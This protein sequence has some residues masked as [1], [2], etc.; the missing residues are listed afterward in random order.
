MNQSDIQ[1]KIWNIADLLRGDFKRSNY[2]RIILPFTVLRRLECV[3]EPIREK[4]IQ[5]HDKIKNTEVNID[6]ILKSTL[7]SPFYNLSE[8]TLASLGETNTRQNISDYINKF[9]SP[10]DKIFENFDFDKWLNDLADAD[11]LFQITQKF[12]L[13]DLHPSR[14]SNHDMGLIFEHLIYKFAESANDT[15]GEFYTPRDVVDLATTLIFDRD[16]DIFSKKRT[17]KTI[18]DPACGTG[19]FLASGIER[20]QQWTQEEPLKP[21]GQELNRESYAIAI[22]DMTIKGFEAKNIHLGNTL[23]DDKL[24]NERFDYCLANPPFGVDW[25]KKETAVRQEHD[26]RGFDGRFGAGL[27]RVSD[28]ALLFLQHLIAKMTPNRTSN[29]PSRASNNG[30]RI[31]IILNGSPLFTGQ[32]GGG[33]SEIRRWILEED[34]LETIIAL[35]TDMFYN[36]GIATYIWLLSNNKPS[37][38]AGKVQLVDATAAWVS[39]RKSIGSKRRE[40]SDQQIKDVARLVQDYKNKKQIYKG[41]A[42]QA[43]V[44][45]STAFGYRRITIERPLQLTFAAQDGARRAALENDKGWKKLAAERQKKIIAALDGVNAKIP[46]REKFFAAMDKA[47]APALASPEKNL[48]QKHIG[49]H[50]PQAHICFKS[51]NKPEADSDLRDY[52]NVPLDTDVSKYFAQ[53]VVPHIPALEIKKPT[54]AER[55][56]PKCWIDE[57]KRDKKDGEIGIVGYE[58]NFNRYFYEYVSPRPLAEIDAELATIEADIAALLNEVAK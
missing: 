32:A 45:D 8:F 21:Y 10:I 41:A 9:S 43:K 25:K 33:E 12:S 15:A 18:Y 36:T 51:N 31:A 37:K 6:K 19:G 20:V 30:G 54:D 53:E 28:G 48:L 46:C 57:D 39:M 13:F 56:T 14:V 52:E 11:L 29:T 49:A 22:A 40:I 35:P 27:P 16:Q 1:A 24:E 26:Q 44:F 4:T 55:D 23:T 47:L 42:L 38:M 2:G 58:I 7:K 50:D 3:I 17:I 5:E 34:L